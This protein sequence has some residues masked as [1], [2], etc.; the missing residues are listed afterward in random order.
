MEIVIASTNKH[1]IEE[2]Q[3]LVKGLDIKFLSLKDINFD[4]EI[5]ENGK[6]FKENSLIKAK[7]IESETNLPILS[8]DSGIIIDALGDNFPGIYSHRYAEENGGSYELNKKLA[9]TV[10]G[11]KAHFC[12]VLTFI[13]NGKVNQFEG[14]FNGKI[15]D[16]V[17]RED[18]FGYDSIFIPEGYNIQVSALS[19]ETKNAMSHR[20]IAFN[21]F[22]N[23][24][25]ENK[26]IY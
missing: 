17:E 22:I 24:L 11:S 23:Y 18:A 19:K 2:Y 10:A 7:A 8:D 12:C 3:Q 13:Y 1:K 15:A 20:S 21:K 14:I 25:K 9:K 26:I 5:V 4:K 16:N 6:T